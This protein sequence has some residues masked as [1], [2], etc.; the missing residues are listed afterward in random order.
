MATHQMVPLA[1]LLLALCA[2]GDRGTPGPR[3][4]LVSGGLC[5][6]RRVR[7]AACTVSDRVQKTILYDITF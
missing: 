3:S 4:K 2:A 6:V 5:T 7:A 1:F